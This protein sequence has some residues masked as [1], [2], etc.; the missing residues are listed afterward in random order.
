M[1][2]LAKLWRLCAKIPYA[3]PEDFVIPQAN[4]GQPVAADRQ[5]VVDAAEEMRRN[6]DNDPEENVM[7]DVKIGRRVYN[8]DYERRYERFKCYRGCPVVR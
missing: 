7:R 1:R 5:K 2:L 4:R 6:Y 8:L 3:F